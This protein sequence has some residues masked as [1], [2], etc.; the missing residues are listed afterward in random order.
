MAAASGWP[1]QIGRNRSPVD[2][3]SRTIGEFVGSSMRTPASVISIIMA[4][5]DRTPGPLV[6]QPSL[7]R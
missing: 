1:T 2:S 3:R 7:R 5:P 6:R 4:V